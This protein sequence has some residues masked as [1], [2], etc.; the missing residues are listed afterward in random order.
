MLEDSLLPALLTLATVVVMFV[1]FVR[2]QY[3]PEVVALSGVALMLATGVLG[4]E[5][6]LGVFANPAPLTIAA[7]FILSGALVRTG[8]LEA[9]SR[10]ILGAATN[11]PRSVLGGL[12]GVTMGASAFMNNT[13]V[14]VMMIPIAGRLAKAFKVSASQLLIPL[15]Y[16]AILGGTCTLIGTSTN[17]LVDGVA[18][19]EGLAPFGLFEITALALPVALLGL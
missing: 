7:M 17:L 5:P 18:Q 15:S 14:V 19:G 13:P 9:V 6:V 16:I 1:L 3:P 10:T 2:E 8:V 12:A 4:I 11:R